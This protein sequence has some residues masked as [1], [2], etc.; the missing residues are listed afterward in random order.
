MDKYMNTGV[1][2]LIEAFP[3]VGQI[4]ERYEIGCTAC[5]LGTCKVQD[6]LK[7]H[8]LEPADQADMMYRIEKA[9]YPGRDVPRPQVQAVA[10]APRARE[11]KY[12]PP[13]RRLVDEHTRIKRLLA[14]IPAMVSEIRAAPEIDVELVLATVDFIR[15]YADKF[16]HMKEEDILFNYCDR[17][18]E[19]VQ[20][21][22]KDHDRARG[23][24]RAAVQALED[25]D[26][27]ALCHN[28]LDYR[29]LLTEH[30]AKEDDILYP[31]IDRGLSTSQ[32]GEMF[33]RFEEAES[34]MPDDVPLRY[35]QFIVNLT[36]MFENIS[37]EEKGSA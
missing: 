37:K 2:P 13:L 3:E 29:E 27:D 36:G 30:I 16:H 24:V 22:F 18:E 14:L 20:V 26:R 33:Q 1:K 5:T 15:G 6:V 32:V 28:L 4:L 35:E 21:I 25:G 7:F 12:S 31:Y 11:I 17:G 9:I 10:G 34:G 23:F 8:V 19:I